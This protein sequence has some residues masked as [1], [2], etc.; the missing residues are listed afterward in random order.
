[1]LTNTIVNGLQYFM[2]ISGSERLLDSISSDPVRVCFCT[3][4]EL[5]CNYQP[6]PVR[7]R[8]GA[9]FNMTVA[10]VDH[11]GHTVSADILSSSSCVSYN[12]DIFE[13]MHPC[14]IATLKTTTRA[15]STNICMVIKIPMAKMQ[16]NTHQDEEA[17]RISEV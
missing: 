12:I 4:R 8:K 3:N 1:M 16:P 9:P 17:R 7:V 5:N 2:N 10:A 13:L 14:T 15:F 6:P 11:V